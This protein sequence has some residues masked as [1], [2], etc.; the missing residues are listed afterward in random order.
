MIMDI[1]VIIGIVLCLGLLIFGIVFA[2]GNIKSYVSLDSFLIV[3]GGT[4]G[5]TLAGI[6]IKE[7]LA[8]FGI[9]RE[10][11]K[12]PKIKWQ[13]TVQLFTELATEARRE[14]VLSLQNKIDQQDNRLIRLGLQ[15]IVDGADSDNLF[16]VM[17]TKIQLR[18][19]KDKLG[20]RI[21]SRMG[22]IAPAFGMLGTV[23]GLIQ[24]LAN[25]SEPEKLG[26]GIA[27]AFMTTF[28]GIAFANIFFKPFA[29]K[30]SKNNE[31]KSR[32]Y[33][34]ILTGVQSI[35]EGD[36]PFIVEEKLK[37]FCTQEPA[38]KKNEQVEE[39]AKETN[40]QVE[41]ESQEKQTKQGVKQY[42]KAEISV[43]TA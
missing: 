25:L 35:H 31:E 12:P 29:N 36:N 33:E 2:G 27:Q 15:L 24:V 17:G 30:I 23:V 4:I 41:A 1:S 20:V 11:M 6:A 40:E 37:A 43:E 22:D 13:D 21:F 5:A 3:A 38:K 10:T 19:S 7:G 8:T 18:K 39:E 32:Y 9:I 34:M 16:Q 42:E 28:Y 14:G 26:S